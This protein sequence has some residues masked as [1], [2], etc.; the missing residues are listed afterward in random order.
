MNDCIY[1]VCTYL[2][3]NISVLR[4]VIRNIFVLFTRALHLIK[5]RRKDGKTQPSRERRSQIRAKSEEHRTEAENE[6]LNR[7][8]SEKRTTEAEDEEHN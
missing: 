6:E 1:S 2:R 7:A 5:E 3:Y 8:K 4:Y